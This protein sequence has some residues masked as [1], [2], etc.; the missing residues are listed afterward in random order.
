[1]RKGHVCMCQV[2]HCK[3][4][5]GLVQEACV[6]DG[7][8]VC[9]L[10]GGQHGQSQEPCPVVWEAQY[11]EEGPV[12]TAQQAKQDDWQV[13][14]TA[15][16]AKKKGPQGTKSTKNKKKKQ[17]P[18]PANTKQGNAD[19][20][21]TVPRGGSTTGWVVCSFPCLVVVGCVAGSWFSYIV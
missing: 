13:V 10:C 15:D 8:A 6:V 12:E 21:V 3:E 11:G 9:K 18:K 17:A 4:Q 2:A 5:E 16:K 1:M 14:L 7:P 20:V 19:V